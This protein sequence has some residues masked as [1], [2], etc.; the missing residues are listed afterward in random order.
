MEP[1]VCLLIDD[2]SE[3]SEIFHYALEELAFKVKCHSVT[4][5]KEALS[6]LNNRPSKPDYIF[7]DLN[8]PRMDGKQCLREIRKLGKADSIPVILYSTAFLEGQKQDLETLGADGFITKTNSVF[9]LHT[10]L[11]KFFASH[12]DKKTGE[13]GST[14]EDGLEPYFMPLRDGIV[15]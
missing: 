12:I 2:D 7:L 9:D 10:E 14:V 6:F 3:E 1:I 15:N 8:M 5:G 13:S 4:S 11:A